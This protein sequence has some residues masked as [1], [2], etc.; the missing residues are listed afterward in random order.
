MGGIWEDTTQ[1]RRYGRRSSVRWSECMGSPQIDIVDDLQPHAAKS[2]VIDK[3]GYGLFADDAGAA[4]VAEKGW[5][6]IYVCG[7]ATESCVLAT[8]L[9]AFEIDLTPWVIED[10]S[11][12]HAGQHV[13]DAGILVTQRFIGVGQVIKVAELPPR[14]VAPERQNCSA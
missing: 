8:A 1:G 5:R 2:Y 9:G 4:L 12:S 3:K 6:D 14:L 13:H 11:A 7:I 10:A